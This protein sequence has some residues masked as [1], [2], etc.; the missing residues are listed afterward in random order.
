MK[1]YKCTKV[2]KQG[3]TLDLITLG[4]ETRIQ[5]E[6]IDEV[7][8]NG[9]VTNDENFLERQ[10]VECAVEELTYEQIKP[11]LD[12]CRLMLEFQDLLKKYPDKADEIN[13]RMKELGLIQ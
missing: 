9:V 13:L 2:Q 4:D 10:H 11:I 3:T 12:N 8:W 1:Y 5:Y 6:N 7:T